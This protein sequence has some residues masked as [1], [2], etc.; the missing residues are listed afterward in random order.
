MIVVVTLQKGRLASHTCL[1]L[2]RCRRELNWETSTLAEDGELVGWTS[3]RRCSV[4]S[5][6]TFGEAKLS[7]SAGC[8]RTPPHASSQSHQVPPSAEQNRAS[9]MAPLTFRWTG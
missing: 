3:I 9:A 1:D 5:G 6:T 4:A 8:A 7:S 2:G